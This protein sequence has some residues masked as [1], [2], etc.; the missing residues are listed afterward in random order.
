V[1]AIPKEP[2][3]ELGNRFE[4]RMLPNGW[5]VWDLS[6]NAPAVV[7]GR[8][9]TDM[10]M[11]DADDMTDLLNRLHDTTALGRHIP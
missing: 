1:S 8:W 3:S 5:C 11:E 10:A 2:I 6:T 9:Q 4:M 7:K